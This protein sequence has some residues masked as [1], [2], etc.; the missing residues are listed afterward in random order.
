[1]S[2]NDKQLLS[3]AHYIREQ[4]RRLNWFQFADMQQRISM[5]V[6]GLDQLQKIQSGLGLC[7]M[8]KWNL[9]ANKLTQ[10]I[11]HVVRDLP[12]PIAE[13]ER[14]V[15]E[16]NSSIPALRTIFE[17]LRQ[18]QA[19]FGRTTY[20]AE[21]RTLSVFTDPIELEGYYLGDFE[22]RLAL[23]GLSQLRDIEPYRVL[24]LDP[25]PAAGND[26]VTH[27]HVSD[28]RVCLGDAMAPVKKALI[29]GRVCDACHLI[30]AVLKTYNSSSPYIALD[31]W[32][33]INCYD[34]GYITHEEEMFYC[35]ACEQDVCDECVSCCKCCETT[36]CQGCLRDC[37]ACEE[38]CC[39]TCLQSC[40]EC[41]EVACLNCL[42][43]EL[44]LTC[45]DEKEDNDEEEITT[46]ECERESMAATNPA[47]LPDRLGQ[48]TLLP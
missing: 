24:A 21:E 35:Q 36:Y 13:L 37:P 5:V 8:Q 33:G 10:R 42:D 29:S 18:L 17:E 22:I 7:K 6:T 45:K 41:G 31:Q 9:S 16:C 48:A 43:D 25:H 15:V 34:C 20:N 28:E 14:A 47:V 26:A 30:K 40:R 1:M 12:Y 2:L 3:I 44:C 4:L 23:T 38:R 19:E 46:T 11:L 32:E 39:E 27:P